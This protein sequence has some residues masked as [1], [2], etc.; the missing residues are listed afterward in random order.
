MTRAERLKRMSKEAKHA[1]W[2]KQE[3]ARIIGWFSSRYGTVYGK[4]LAGKM[5]RPVPL[6]ERGR[7]LWQ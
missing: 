4:M 1:R 7:S 2:N 3:D 5:L 6:S